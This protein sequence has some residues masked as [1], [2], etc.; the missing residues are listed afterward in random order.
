M[1]RIN[2]TLASRSYA[3]EVGFAIGRAFRATVSK[4]L[5]EGRLFLFF[6]A[7]FFA[8][9]GATVRRQLGL[10][11]KRVS[12]FVVP[13]GERF[14]TPATI[15]HLQTY[16]LSEQISR[17]DLIVACGGGVLTDLVGYAAATVLR[18][19]RWGAVPT[20]LLGMVDAAIGGKTGVNHPHGK[21][22]IGAIWQPSFVHADLTWLATLP[23]RELIAGMGEIVKYA[24]LQGGPTLQKLQKL[25]I[26]AVSTDRA[27]LLPLIAK[28]VRYKAEI[29]S[30]D[31]RESG[32]RMFLN[33][34][35][36]FAHG[37][38][39][40]LGYGKL[41]HGEA[42]LIGLLAMW[43]VSVAG[44]DRIGPSMESYRSIIEQFIRHIP[45]RQ[46][47]PRQV[48]AA[49]ATDKKRLGRT[50]R[51]VLLSRPGQPF[52]DSSVTAAAARRALTA[53]LAT[54]REYGGTNAAN[55]GR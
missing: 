30:N 10:P 24:G 50:V 28:A 42:V 26:A 53:A 2:V 33:L 5:G 46:L 16:L 21:N 22:L 25:D 44:Q 38:E 43:H 55:S 47:D 18:G 48:V 13:S 32:R 3:V 45:Y 52:I 27:K 6:D 11:A 20:T 31:E 12:E 34:G 14:K 40:A 19:V 54:Y 15:A 9:H 4:Q 29:V 36:T 17:N 41:L 51:F 39:N 35:H 7:G 1:P 49:M 8:L 23:S 37:I